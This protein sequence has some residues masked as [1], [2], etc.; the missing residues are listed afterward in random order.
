MAQLLQLHGDLPERFPGHE[1][2]LH[3]FVCRKKACRRKEGSIRVIRSVRATPSLIPP[4]MEKPMSMPP[5]DRGLGNDLFD[6]AGVPTLTPNVNPFSASLGRLDTR[7]N[8]FAKPNM[9]PDSPSLWFGA[10]SDLPMTFAQKVSLSSTSPTRDLEPPEPW[11]V[12]SSLPSPFPLYHLDAD[13]ETLDAPSLPSAPPSLPMDLDNVSRTSSTAPKEDLETFESTMDNTFQRFADRLAQNPQ[14]VLRY[15]FEGMPLLYSR[16][17]SVGR[18]LSLRDSS[19]AKPSKISTIKEKQRT[20][21]PACTNCGS[22]RVFEMQITP[23][24]IAELEVDETGLDG[25]DWGTLIIGVCKQDCQ[26]RNVLQ[27]EAGHVEEWVGVQWEEQ[28]K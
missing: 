18:L 2:R 17:D 9:A 7:S 6:I 1:R 20:G 13:Y 19:S 5:I 10:S 23:Q 3:V 25:M 27:G 16:N 24:A 15:E 12:S 8:P 28:G 26:A 14:Q 22:G 4:T 21:I 11:P